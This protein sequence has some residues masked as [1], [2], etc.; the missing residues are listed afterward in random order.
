MFVYEIYLEYYDWSYTNVDALG[1]VRDE[2]LAEHI[3]SYNNKCL[4][5][6]CDFQNKLLDEWIDYY[7]DSWEIQSYLVKEINNYKKDLDFRLNGPDI[8]S[9]WRDTGQ[10]KYVIRKTN[11]PRVKSKEYFNV[12]LYKFQ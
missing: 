3:V 7:S 5:M 9:V 8:D 11:I 10:Y 6:L 12:S 4:K 1:W 2:E